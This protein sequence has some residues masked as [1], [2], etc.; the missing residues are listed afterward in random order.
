MPTILRDRLLLV[1]ALLIAVTLFSAGIGGGASWFGTRRM[2]AVAVLAIAF[3]KAG[4]V[5]FAFME[6][7][8]APL[9][10]RILAAGWLVAALAVLLAAYAGM[11]A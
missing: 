3:V 1:W 2:V 10:L 5:M 8:R 6:L 4:T 11:L 7:G 9:A